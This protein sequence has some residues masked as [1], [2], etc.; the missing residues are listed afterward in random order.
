MLFYT[1]VWS[2][3][4]SVVMTAQYQDLQSLYVDKISYT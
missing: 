3:R 2:D 1:K 4:P